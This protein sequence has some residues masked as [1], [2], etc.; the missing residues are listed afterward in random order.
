MKKEEI[1]SLVDDAKAVVREEFARDLLKRDA[2]IGELSTSLK[3]L[4][5]ENEKLKSANALAAI[6]REILLRKIDQ[7]EQ[8]SRKQN[9]IIDGINLRKEDNDE[10]IRDAVLEE[11]AN[12]NLDIDPSHVVRAH[13]TGSSYIDSRGRRHTPVICRFISWRARNIVYEARKLSKYYYKADLTTDNSQLFKYA[14]DAVATPDS[15][16]NHLISFVFVDRNCRLSLK[17]NDDHFFKFNSQAEFDSLLDKIEN[18]KPHVSDIYRG[19]DDSLKQRCTR[20]TLVNVTNIDLEAWIQ[21]DNHI[22]IGRTHGNV[23]G[24]YWANEF[25][26]EEHGRD[27]A[28]RLYH[29]KVVNSPQMMERLYDLRGMSLGCWCSWPDKCHGQ[30]LINLLSDLP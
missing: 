2:I 13:R 27:T 8:Y 12:L 5:S 18:T 15:S 24:S 7:N 26:V 3:L 30:L 21:E 20:T 19:I 9:L 4:K 11:L 23:V 17:T 10:V 1:I 6:H 16:A 28:L 29:Q 22:Y 14:V 25:K